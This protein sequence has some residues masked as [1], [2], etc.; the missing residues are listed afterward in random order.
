MPPGQIREESWNSLHH[1]EASGDRVDN[2]YSDASMDDEDPKDNEHDEHSNIKSPAFPTV[3]DVQRALHP[4]QAT[5][6]RVG[7]QVELFAENLDRLS[8]KKQRKAETNGSHI[9][10]L[11][12]AYKKIATDTVRHLGSMH[13]P[14]RRQRLSKNTK[15]TLRKSSGRFIPAPG[16]ADRSK[17]NSMMTT[18]E[19]LEFWEQEEQT[20]D[21]LE[22]M[23]RT[24]YP[25][26]NSANLPR[27]KSP[28]LVRPK[29]DE[30]LHHYSPESD[31]WKSFLASDD[32]A[33]ERHTVLTW[34][35]KSADQ[36]G[37]DIEQVVEELESGADR[38]TGLWAH[39]WLYSK[40]AIK[41]QKRL[42]SWPKALEP[43]APGLDASLLN[44]DKTQPLVTQLDPDAVT[45]QGRALELQDQCFERAIWLACWEMVR[46]GKD[47][48]YMREWCEQRVENW[49]ATAMHGDFRSAAFEPSST[50]NWQSRALWRKTCALAAKEGGIDEYESAVYGVL[51]GYLPSVLK[52]SRRWDDH[53]FAHYNSY[54]LH[55]FDH[56]T[57]VNFPSRVSNQLSDQHSSFNFSIFGGQ[58][59]LS[60]NQLVEKMKH[61]DA[62]KEEALT[63]FKT[64]QGSLIAKAFDEF[65]FRHGAR[66]AKSANAEGK[67]KTV[68]PMS[69]SILEG[70]VTADLRMED[71]ELLRLITHIVF[72]YQDLGFNFGEGDRLYAMETIIVAYIDF[73]SKAGK[74]QLLPLY[75]SRLSPQRSVACLGRQL[76]SIRDREERQTFIRLMT[77]QGI[78]VPDVLSTH[79]IMIITDTPA[80]EYN[81]ISESYPKLQILEPSKDSLIP[82]QIRSNFVGRAM[83]EDQQDLIRGFEWYLLL[84]RNWRETMLVGTV[85]Y[86]HLLRKSLVVICMTELG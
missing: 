21:L 42:R 59:V 80:S 5:A 82:R 36:S 64:L 24:E 40:E 83:T 46:R 22:L 6:D 50:A 52:V 12:D 32:Q 63:P 86:K 58:R 51:S 68:E 7:K 20:W 34:L 43:D 61:I 3:S 16:A 55:S 29:S 13:A 9:I 49:R 76:S 25:T 4:L 44:S 23:L 47:W 27:D 70:T 30:K 39:S 57:K 11:V 56:Y 17:D 71:Y 81:S 28:E 84:E 65:I 45:R 26:L 60:G 8:I 18:F 41:G 85:V 66:L 62:I 14:E 1:S 74:Q 38:G 37:Q 67:S 48:S 78:S 2:G 31:L 73:L 15:H 69:D 53:L 54:L 33:W 35:R 10:P 72:I 77:Q 19:D 79:L 75:A